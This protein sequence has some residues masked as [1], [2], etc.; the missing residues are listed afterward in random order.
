VDPC[1][2]E[3]VLRKHPEVLD[4]VVY[5]GRRDDGSE[6]VQAAVCTSRPVRSGELRAHC[7]D[8]LAAHKVPQVVHQVESVPRT[9]SGKCRKNELPQAASSP[10][11]GASIPNV[12]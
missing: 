5:A 9:A 6:F 10:K 8:R 2:V 11:P 3:E 4:V 1:E 12:P 7:Q